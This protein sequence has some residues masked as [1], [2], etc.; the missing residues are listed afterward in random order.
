MR[1]LTT[2]FF[3]LA[4]ASPLLA[5]STRSADAH[6][7][8]QGDLAIAIEGDQVAMRLEA[9]GFD[10]VGFE[11]EAKSEEDRARLAQGVAEL[12]KPLSLFRLPDAAAC[13]VTSAKADLVDDHDDH[14]HEA[15]NHDHDGHDHD[16]HEAAAEHTE[17][18]AE[19]M[20]VCG[21]T[22][23]I[24]QI[25]FAYFE[26]FPNAEELDVQIVTDKGATGLEVSRADPVA[27]LRGMF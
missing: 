26:V 23:A 3:A 25:E 27:N 15:H 6:V 19:Y 17:F 20:L 21:D 22:S 18:E 11:H 2:S 13:T 8:G 4:A 12:A 10:I 14:D 16:D 24:D 5:D 1:I 7:H 9:P